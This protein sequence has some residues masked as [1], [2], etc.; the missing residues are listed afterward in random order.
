MLPNLK[1]V[2]ETFKLGNHESIISLAAL[3]KKGAKNL[4]VQR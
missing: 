3:E 4:Q 1:P 2:Q